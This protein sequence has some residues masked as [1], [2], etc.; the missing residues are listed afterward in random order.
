MSTRR[1][2]VSNPVY[3]SL[4]KGLTGAWNP[5]LAPTILSCLWPYWKFPDRVQAA[6]SEKLETE[7]AVLTTHLGLSQASGSSTLQQTL[8]TRDVCLCGH[9]PTGVPRTTHS[10]QNAG[11]DLTP[12]PKQER[13]AEYSRRGSVTGKDLNLLEG[14]L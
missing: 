11:C 13:V 14:M 1:Q 3:F 12:S 4:F 6:G 8:T 9:T 10:S 2:A 5:P 7:F